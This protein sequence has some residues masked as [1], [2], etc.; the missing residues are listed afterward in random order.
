MPDPSRSKRTATRVGNT[1]R[2]FVFG[3]PFVFAWYL[4]WIVGAVLVFVFL[5][6]V[7]EQ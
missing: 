1:I 2:P 3:V 7:F 5:Y 6:R 4:F